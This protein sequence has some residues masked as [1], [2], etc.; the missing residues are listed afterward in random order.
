MA[1][2]FAALVFLIIFGVIVIAIDSNRFVVREYT[3]ESDRIG[4]DQ[5]FLFVSDLHCREYGKGNEKLLSAI[6]NIKADYALI[7]GD[8]MVSRPGRDQQTGVDFVKNLCERMPVYFAYGNHEHRAKIHE[9]TYGKLY[10]EFETAVENDN[11]SW[12]D[13]K[14][15]DVDGVRITGFTMEEPYYLRKFK[16]NMKPDYIV[17]TVGEFHK[18]SF[19]IMLAHDP[20]YFDTYCETDADLVLS[21][22]FHGGIARLPFIGGVISPRFKLFPAY[23]GGQYEKNGTKIIV[24]CG[25]GMHTIPLRFNNPAE[26]TVVHL[27]KH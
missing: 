22:H 18:N 13:N 12:L 7:G 3:I 26:L 4:K 23:A 2:V 5:T 19:N 11:L 20:E 27:K 21:G 17:K 8:I 24:S 15:V 14:S 1:Y 9:K 6:D 16:L 10:E 25:L